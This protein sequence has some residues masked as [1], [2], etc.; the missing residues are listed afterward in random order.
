MSQ[1]PPRA[2]DE[3]LLSVAVAIAD[4]TPIDWNTADTTGVLNAGS[5]VVRLQHLERLVRGHEAI[6]AR[7][8]GETGTTADETVL[9]A[10]RRTQGLQ[11]PLDVRWGPLVI[12]DKIGRGSFGDV[13]RA[14]DP[15]LEREVALKLVPEQ[16]PESV[17]SPVVEEGRLLARVRHPNVLTVYG[18]ERIDGRAGIWTEYLP[19]ETLAQE[20]ARRGPVPA[21]EAARIGIEVCRALDAVH[22]A[23]LLHRDVK[24]QN[25]LDRKSVV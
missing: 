11:A 7:P 20:I 4:G 12:L 21:D 22:G 10:A 25:V 13:Y 18:A 6:R 17:S 15:R 1:P 19:G 8:G 16:T 9:T 24:A 23:G 3:P 14:W 2:D 5:M